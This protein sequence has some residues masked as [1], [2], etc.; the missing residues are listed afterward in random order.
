MRIELVAALGPRQGRSRRSVASLSKDWTRTGSLILRPHG[1]LQ[2]SLRCTAV[3]RELG[4]H[5]VV[6]RTLVLDL[7][8]DL[9]AAVRSGA[10]IGITAERTDG[11]N[12]GQLSLPKGHP[13]DL[14]SNK[15]TNKQTN[16]GAPR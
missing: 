7:P 5:R 13:A 10:V 6:S 12:C 3:L 14:S 15:Q 4:R 9:Q 2:M 8:P 16:K 11:H 1:L